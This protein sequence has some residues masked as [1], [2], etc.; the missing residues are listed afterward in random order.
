M[1]MHRVYSDNYE[2][3]KSYSTLH[4]KEQFLISPTDINRSFDIISLSNGFEV[5]II[6]DSSTDK[7]AAAID[8]GVGSSSDPLSY[9]G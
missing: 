6:S 3:W 7:S 9:L 2:S 8:I 1:R 5:L 4:E